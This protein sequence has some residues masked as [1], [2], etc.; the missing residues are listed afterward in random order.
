MYQAIKK[1]PGNAR[2]FGM[3]IIHLLVHF[4]MKIHFRQINI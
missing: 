4:K 1:I 3:Q 2:N